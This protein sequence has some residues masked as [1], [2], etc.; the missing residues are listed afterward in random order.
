MITL[1][2]AARSRKKLLEKAVEKT[3]QKYIDSKSHLQCNGSNSTHEYT[4]GLFYCD[5]LDD[6]SKTQKDIKKSVQSCY[7]YCCFNHLVGLP[8]IKYQNEDG[9]TIG[10]SEPVPLWNYEKEIISRYEETNYY[11]LNK[12]R[13]AGASELFIRYLLFKALTATIQ[14]RKVLIVAGINQDSAQELMY[15]MK[16]LADKLR[17]MYRIKPQSDSPAALF[18]KKGII[19]A[20]PAK[21]SALRLLENVGNILID[22]SAFW[23]L[24]DDEVVLTAAEPHVFKSNAHIAVVSTPN[25]QRGFFWTRIFNPDIK[26]KYDKHTL[27]WTEVIDEPNQLPS[28]ERYVRGLNE[29][30]FLEL[31]YENSNDLVEDL[32][33]LNSISLESWIPELNPSDKEIITLGAKETRVV[34]TE[35]LKKILEHVDF[36]RLGSI[37]QLGLIT[38]V[39]PSAKHSRLEHSL[40]TYAHTCEYLRALWYNTHDPLFRSIMRKQDLYTIML[41]ALLHDI[42]YYP[43]AHDLEDCSKWR[44]CGISHEN[45][46]NKIITEKLADIFKKEWGIKQPKNVSKLINPDGELTFKEKIL[47]T[48]ISSPIDSDK[49]DYLLRDGMHLGLPYAEGI[50]KQWF[51]RNLTIAYGP[52]IKPSIAITDKGRVAAELIATVRFHMFTVAYWHHT[53]RSFKAMLKYAIER[54]DKE[55]TDENEYYNWFQQLPYTDDNL[56]K[57]SNARKVIGHTD[58]LQLCWIR[59]KLDDEGKAVIDL[60]LRRKLYKRIS[61]FEKNSPDNGSTYNILINLQDREIENIRKQ[62]ESELK[63]RIIDEGFNEAEN[64]KL[65]VLIDTPKL[66]TESNQLYVVSELGCRPIS[67]SSLIWELLYGSSAGSIGKVRI[68]VHPEI[69][70]TINQIL[71]SKELS[72]LITKI[73]ESIPHTYRR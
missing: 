46:A 10:E 39:Y 5:W 32:L 3:Y 34:L 62:I 22:E 59:D 28:F 65:L 64:L 15:R 27:N 9:S 20:L 37:T 35:R 25:G 19:L 54:L 1:E 31:A 56:V 29:E 12:C 26:T 11:A 53:V 24:I 51:L 45:Y 18:F 13:G 61:V 52:D 49:L 50:D 66:Q 44:D 23:N 73:V 21:P 30:N 7:P 48:I 72:K 68:F 43:L 16:V 17:F 47:H 8:T 41:A 58:F 14:D 42:G 36:D 33:K 70:S 67:Q 40:G 60:I 4:L 55:K 71:P 57:V 63:K 38:Y 69:V 6:S 2:Q